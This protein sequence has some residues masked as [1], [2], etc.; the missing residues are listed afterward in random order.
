M[1]KTP[2]EQEANCFATNLLVPAS[3]LQQYLDD[4]PDITN[5]QLSKAFGVSA[6][7]I[8]YRRLYIE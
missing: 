5:Q 3:F 4:F 7:V 6:E 8:H 1:V 2:I